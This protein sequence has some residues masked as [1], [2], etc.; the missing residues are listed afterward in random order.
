MGANTLWAYVDQQGTEALAG[1]VCIDQTPRMLNADDW[2]HGFYGYDATNAGTLFAAGAPRTG[3]GRSDEASLE[4]M[5]RLVTR[6]GGPPAFRDGSAPETL[7]LLQD[8]ALQDYRDVVARAACPVLMVAGRESQLWP[9][10][11]AAAAV[12]DNPYGRSVV[13]E[14]AGHAVSFDQPDALNA[15]LLDFLGGLDDPVPPAR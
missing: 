8:H 15:V 10:E 12:A 9:C 5:M 6:L 14:D 2:P 11:H 13:I 4:Q 3:R 7:R 1:I